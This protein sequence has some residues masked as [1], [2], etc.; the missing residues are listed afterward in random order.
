[1]CDSPTPH[2][3]DL[4]QLRLEMDFLRLL[5]TLRTRLSPLRRFHFRKHVHRL[6]RYW[7]DWCCGFGEW[8]IEYTNCLRPHVETPGIDGHPSRRR[9]DWLGRWPTV[10]RTVHAIRD[11]AMVSHNLDQ[12]A[13]ISD[14]QQVFLHQPADWGRRCSSSCFPPPAATFPKAFTAHSA[15][16]HPP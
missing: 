5:P 7:R 2:G 6:P 1:M 14:G 8:I 16:R 10:W 12:S 13:P 3:K 9:P 11:L 15:A 4:L